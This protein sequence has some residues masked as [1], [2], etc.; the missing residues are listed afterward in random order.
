MTHQ[1]P[2]IEC[3]GAYILNERTNQIDKYLSKVTLLATGGI[4]NV[5]SATSNP[6]VATGD[7]IAMAHRARAIIQDMEFVQFHP[8]VLYNPGVR[9]SF[10]ITEALRG[11]GAILA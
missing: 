1:T 7:G 11:Y 5:Y 2:N 4:G 9:P 10:L 8:T 6:V 3:Y